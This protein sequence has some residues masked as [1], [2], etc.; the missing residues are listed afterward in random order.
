MAQLGFYTLV[1]A[2]VLAV[3]AAAASVI[4]QRLRAPEMIAS[5][6]RSLY[7]VTAALTLSIVILFHAFAVNDFSLKFVADHSNRALPWYYAISS[8]WAGQQGSLLFWVW[9]LSVYAGLVTYR[10]RAQHQT[11][12]PYVVAVLSVNIF[13]FVLLLLFIANP[14]EALPS[15]NVPP[16]GRGLNPLLQHPAMMI[17]PPC[18]YLGL[19]GL[20]VPFAFAMAALFSGSLGDAWIR[21]SRRWMLFPWFFLGIG[22]LLGGRWAYVEL[23]WGGY[24]AWDPVENASLMPWLA[25]TAYIHSVM[26]QE[27]R[28]MMKFWNHFLVSL[29]FGLAMLGTFITRSGIVSSVH[30]FAQSPIGTYFLGFIILIVVGTG[31]MFW[32]RRRELRTESRLDS[33]LSRES[34]FLLNNLILLGAC[35]AVLWGTLF[36]ILSEALRGVRVAVGPPWFNQVNVPIGLILLALTGIGPLIAWRR[37]SGKNLRRMFA[38]PVALALLGAL[39]FLALGMFH[40]YAVTSFSLSIFVVAGIFQE[41][42]RGIRARRRQF[43]ES[44]WLALRRLVSKNRRRYGG[45]IVHLGMVSVFVGITGAAFN[46]EREATLKPEETVEIGDYTLRYEGV[47][48][49]RD[50]NHE[51]ANARFSVY[52]GTRYLTDM[53]PAKHFYLASQQPTTEVA[54]H[55]TLLEDLYIAIAS[56]QADGAISLKVYLNPLV[57]WLWIGGLIFALGTLI[58]MWP[59]PMDRRYLVP[60]YA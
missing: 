41:F 32:F 31:F 45:Y 15:F 54:I 17:H 57:Q 25:A 55:T 38:A 37:A 9:I 50:A 52:K 23:G 48:T 3:Y 43:Q 29:S 42:W 51:W 49:G 22:V 18:L 12:M 5:G 4:G 27:K 21:I 60:K 53:I 39:V 36:P 28:D 40:G 8:L 10:N 13:F 6:R 26:I 47:E 16:D 34:S 35:F 44:A 56:V 19:V 30:S 33:Y 58:I 20:A 7:A 24:W 11:F 1:L 46:V 59:D 14:F 2:F